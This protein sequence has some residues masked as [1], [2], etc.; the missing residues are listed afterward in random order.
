MLANKE[1]K[2]TDNCLALRGNKWEL[3]VQWIKCSD[4]QVV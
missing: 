2:I 3:G 1:N 4:C